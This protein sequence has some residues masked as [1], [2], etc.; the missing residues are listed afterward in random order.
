MFVD[1]KIKYLDYMENGERCKGV[2]FV[3]IEVWDTLC[4]FQIQVSGMHITDSYVRKVTLVGA[5]K[6]HVISELLLNK[7]KGNLYIMNL[8]TNNMAGSGIAYA[9]LLGIRIPIAAG[10]EIYCK[11][12]EMREKKDVTIVSELQ[13]KSEGDTVSELPIDSEVKI[14]SELV[15]ESEQ[16]NIKE[17][18][19]EEIHEQQDIVSKQQNIKQEADKEQDKSVNEEVIEE[20]SIKKLHDN[21]WNQLVS[22]YPHIC[23][24]R[25]EREYLSIGPGDFVLLP[26]KY[27]ALANNS[28]L[29]HGYYNY[30]H[31]I[32]NRVEMRNQ[33]NYYIG[34]P[35]NF[36]EREK[37]VAILFGFESFE[38]LEEPARVGDYGYYMMKVE[39]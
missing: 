1:R 21:K 33:V 4:N 13:V 5:D 9:E 23:P 26:E 37:Q 31:L 22:I 19:L 34:V 30:G 14:K 16:L 39:L 18:K 27:Y 35:G 7:G 3:K 28:F 20:T 11:L 10:K 12:Q 24:F 17:K 36:Y 15:L 2:G 6:E 29:L 32:L 8:D 38:C 25:D